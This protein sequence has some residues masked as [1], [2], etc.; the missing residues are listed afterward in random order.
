MIET[1]R[2]GAIKEQRRGEK[3]PKVWPFFHLQPHGEGG[4]SVPSVSSL[5]GSLRLPWIAFLGFAML[6]REST[7]NQ[8]VRKCLRYIESFSSNIYL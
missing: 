7:D 2:L 6:C 8:A 3:G 5:L 1:R 4:E